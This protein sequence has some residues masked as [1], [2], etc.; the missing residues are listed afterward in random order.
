MDTI[1]EIIEES[2]KDILEKFQE[3]KCYPLKEIY[4]RNL[5]TLYYVH[6]EVKKLYLQRQLNKMIGWK[7]GLVSDE[8][9]K[10]LDDLWDKS[11]K[12]IEKEN[13]MIHR[14]LKKT[15]K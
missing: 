10:R 8:D 2:I 14:Y 4:Y 5:R 7:Q 15:K 13:E 6:P 11:E 12:R 3:G 1:E 9:L